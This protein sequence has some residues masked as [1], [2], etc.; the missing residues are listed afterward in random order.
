MNRF[1]LMVT[2]LVGGSA[3]CVQEAC[4]AGFWDPEVRITNMKVVARDA[5]TATI[6]FDVSWEGSWRNEVNHDAAWIFFKARKAGGADPSTPLRAGWQHVRLAADRVLNPT[7]YGQKMPPKA[8][9]SDGALPYHL[10]GRSDDNRPG[11]VEYSRSF[12]TRDKADAPLEFLV[13]DGKDGFTGVF[14]QRA[15]NGAGTAVAHGVTVVWDLTASKGLGDP[16]KAQL[17]AFGHEMVYVDEGSFALGTGSTETY[18]FYQY[19]DGDDKTNPYWVK[20]PGAIPTGRKPGMLWAPKTDLKDGGE[21]PASFPNGYSAFYC[22]KKQVTPR[23]YAYFLNVLTPAQVKA[24]YALP[25]KMNMSSPIVIP[26]AKVKALN[27][28]KEGRLPGEAFSFKKGGG[29]GAGVGVE[30]LSW[31]DGAAYA[32]WAGLRPM[33]ELEIEKLVRGPREPIPGEVGPCYWGAVGFPPW[34]WETIKGA[35]TIV[36]IAVTVGNAKGRA[37]KGTHGNGTLSLPADWPQADAVGS[38]TRCVGKRGGALIGLDRARVSDRL[39]A[40]VTDPARLYKFRCVR[41]APVTKGKR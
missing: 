10:P 15:E 6:Q 25:D 14:L 22:M 3:L 34:Q 11:G 19:A 29:R 36:E 31:V 28:P 40:A 7:G 18:A 39:T 2:L 41:T 13:P 16:G 20:S 38:G 30:P 26:A 8:Q 1:S 23:Q 4:A 17:R 37:F 35:D 12:F 24:R 33:T 32:A 9:A 5:K 21:I 27:I